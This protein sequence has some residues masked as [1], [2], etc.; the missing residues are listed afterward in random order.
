MP[1]FFN[2]FVV[3]TGIEPVISHL[4]AYSTLGVSDLVRLPT[5][6]LTKLTMRV[7]SSLT[8]FDIP[9]W[10]VKPDRAFLYQK[11]HMRYHPT[12]HRIGHTIR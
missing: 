9:P 8:L 1:P 4:D 5:R 7:R 10:L 6:H 2:N 12:S 3:R 11:F